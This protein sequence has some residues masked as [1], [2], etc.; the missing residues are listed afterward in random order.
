MSCLFCINWRKPD[1]YDWQSA[2]AQYGK[3]TLNPVW[4]DTSQMHY[5]ASMRTGSTYGRSSLV[6]ENN[7][8][9]HELV[10]E[11]REAKKEISRLRSVGKSLRAKQKATPATPPGSPDERSDSQPQLG[12]SAPK[13]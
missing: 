4:I 2:E 8:S 10:A 7:R 12:Q 9:M 11:L 3:C 5:C 6:Y 13:R 1:P